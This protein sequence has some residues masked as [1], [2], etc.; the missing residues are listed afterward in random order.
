MK[1]AYTVNSKKKTITIDDNIAL[2]AIDEKDISMYVNG[3]YTIRHKSEK[4]ALK[5]TVRVN[6]NKLS[7]DIITKVL[8]E[9]KKPFV[10][11]NHE[12]YSKE[13]R[14]PLE[15]YEDIK[16]SK[17]KPKGYFSAKSF[18]TKEY[19]G[20]KTEKELAE[21]QEKEDKI[22]EELKEAK[23]NAEA[24]AKAEAEAKEQKEENK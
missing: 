17:V 15:I 8:A 14:T 10:I 19:K 18:Y 2:T 11:E 6:Q 21:L 20:T 23:A 3:G 12:F 5:A 13:T 1:K 22:R 9:D 24:K 4:R 16:H 7:D